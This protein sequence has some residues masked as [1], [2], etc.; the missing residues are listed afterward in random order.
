[1][2]GRRIQNGVTAARPRK[3]QNAS[4]TRALSMINWSQAEN[5]DEW[6]LLALMLVLLLLV[7]TDGGDGGEPW[8]RRA[9]VPLAFCLFLGLAAVTPFWIRRPFNWWMVNQR[10][11]FPA[12][13][14]AV[15]FPRGPIRGSRSALLGGALLLMA[16]LPLQTARHYRD[17]SRRAAPLV[18]LIES[19]PLGSNTLVLHRPG[20]AFEDPVLAP[21]MTIWREL[22]NDPLVYRGG[23]DPYLYD[24]GFPIKRIHALPAPKVRRAAELSVSPDETRFHPD[25]MMRGWDYFIVTDDNRDA[26]PADGAVV[27]RAAGGWTLY[28]NVT[29]AP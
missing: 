25:T 8:R 28:R 18:E 27:V 24:D 5:A 10:F 3:R 14:I 22:Y 16:W 4:G 11:L 1:L 7:V 12:A 9:R 19:T 20:R 21:D 26:M 13:C 15:F 23:F 17:F 2:K 29:T 6:I